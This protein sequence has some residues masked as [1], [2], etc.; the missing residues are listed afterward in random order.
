MRKLNEAFAVLMVTLVALNGCSKEEP[1]PE[2]SRIKGWSDFDCV[3]GTVKTFRARNE[4]E[5][6]SIQF[7]ADLG[8]YIV[9]ET[10]N[11]QIAEGTYETIH[12]VTIPGNSVPQKEGATFGFESMQRFVS[13][14][15]TITKLDRENKL[16][17]G[18]YTGVA[19]GTETRFKVSGSFNDVPLP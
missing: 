17:S 8:P 1:C 7:R 5:I 18:H 6:L 4:G 11:S 12:N 16:V 15:V 9:I 13:A 14:T 3:S 2:N 19:D 10:Y